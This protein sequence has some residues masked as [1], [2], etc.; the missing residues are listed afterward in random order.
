[1][2]IYF[3]T[4]SETA[5]GDFGES[6]TISTVPKSTLIGNFQLTAAVQL[7]GG[8]LASLGQPT[9]ANN[10]LSQ[11][12]IGEGNRSNNPVTWQ[13]QLTQQGYVRLSYASTVFNTAGTTSWTVPAGVYS[14]NVTVIGGG[15]GGAGGASRPG[16]NV[17]YQWGGG[18]GGGGAGGKTTGTI[19]VSPGN[20]YT[21]VVGSGGNGSSGTAGGDSSTASPGT[22]SSAFGLA[23][24]GGSAGIGARAYCCGGDP[25]SSYGAGGAGGTGNT[26]T[27]GTGG[28]GS[29]GGSGPSGGVHTGGATATGTGAGSNGSVGG[30]GDFL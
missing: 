24:G 19:S 10:Y 6:V 12:Q 13:I 20:T 29:R 30:A 25:G 9:A 17:N 8:Y 14:V 16:G 18:G 3:N 22:G 27:G 4:D 21:I 5:Q 23:A 1:M 15:G 7:S 2:G 28:S 26:V 11:Y